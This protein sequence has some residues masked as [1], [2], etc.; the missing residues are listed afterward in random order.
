MKADA[1]RLA[2][3]SAQPRIPHTN[4]CTLRM[5]AE[6]RM[7]EANYNKEYLPIEGLAE[8]RKATI[9]L[10]LGPN[11]KAQQEVRGSRPSA[12]AWQRTGAAHGG[13]AED[14]EQHILPNQ[15]AAE[16]SQTRRLVRSLLN[17]PATALSSMRAFVPVAC[18]VQP[19]C[20]ALSG[21]AGTASVTLQVRRS[22]ALALTSLFI[23]CGR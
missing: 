23:N 9:D 5:Q 17:R 11:S 16:M 15:L 12:R 13:N 2:L 3:H 7:L 21:A 1:F 14:V 18:V 20:T 19:G 4:S 6:Q 8:F 10:M 22:S